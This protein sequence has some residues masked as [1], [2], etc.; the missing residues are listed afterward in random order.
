MGVCIWGDGNWVSDKPGAL[1]ECKNCRTR[2]GRY[3]DW[4]KAKLDEHVDKL[5]VRAKTADT[6]QERR[7]KHQRSN[8]RQLRPPTARHRQAA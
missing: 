4:P 2:M 7:T 1:K 6:V 5:H 3:E 8:V